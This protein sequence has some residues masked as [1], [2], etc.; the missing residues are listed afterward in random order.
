[1]DTWLIVM[2]LRHT[3]KAHVML[4]FHTRSILFKWWNNV[5][6]LFVV[7]DVKT[8]SQDDRQFK[9]DNNGCMIWVKY[10][11]NTQLQI[12]SYHFHFFSTFDFFWGG[13]FVSLT[14]TKQ[15]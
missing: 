12:G 14:L 13:F 11:A 4:I 2:H 1:M 7:V 3:L 9:N 6:M 8:A 10:T 5:G 15:K